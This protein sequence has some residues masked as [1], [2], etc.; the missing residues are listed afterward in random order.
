M[1]NQL[2]FVGRQFE[3]AGSKWLVKEGNQPDILVQYH[4]EPNT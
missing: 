4:A 2:T 1:N 3:V